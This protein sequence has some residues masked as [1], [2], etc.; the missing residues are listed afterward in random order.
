[1]PPRSVS[2]VEAL[3]REGREP[4]ALWNLGFRPFYLL[5]SIFASISILLWIA[6]YAGV[7]PGGYLRDP[8]WHAHEMLFGYTIAVI[9][10]FLFTAG[11]NWT[12]K[13]TPT[14]GLLMAYTLL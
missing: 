3:P 5:A 2:S 8:V 1:M 10:G 14:G 7:L 13:P 4:F 12:G 9:T 6:D 11:R